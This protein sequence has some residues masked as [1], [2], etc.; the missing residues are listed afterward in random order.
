MLNQD[1]N[2]SIAPHYNQNFASEFYPY[3][4]QWLHILIQIG[5]EY[6]AT[7]FTW[8]AMSP[9]SQRRISQSKIPYDSEIS[10]TGAF[11]L[12]SDDNLEL[13]MLMWRKFWN[14]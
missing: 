13:S 8:V 10:I 6:S 2:V 5:I 12:L 11:D 4:R 14:H 1:E 9:D 3:W 7:P